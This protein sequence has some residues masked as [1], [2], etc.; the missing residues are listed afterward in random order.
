RSLGPDGANANSITIP[1]M[2]EALSAAGKRFDFLL[3]D[4]CMMAS[5]EV[6]YELRD[7]VDYNISSVIDVPIEGF[8]YQEMFHKLSLFSIDGY[9]ET[10]D[11]Y[12][13]YYT[14]FGGFGTMSL[15]DCKEMASLA[16]AVKKEIATHSSSIGTYDNANLQFYGDESTGNRIMKLLSADMVQ[17]IR[18]INDGVLPADFKTQFDKALL[19]TTYVRDS[20]SFKIDGDNYCGVGMYLPM[21]SRRYWN[22]YFQTLGWYTAAGW[23]AVTWPL[24]Q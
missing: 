12:V 5:S 3:F 23:D 9:K 8:P 16:Q 13:D 15:I 10:C 6:L 4:A 24:P 17:F 20:Y 11:A 19:Y 22:E 18:L 7:V 1:D 2:A 21:Q 14:R